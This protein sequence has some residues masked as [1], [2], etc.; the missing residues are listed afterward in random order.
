MSTA[1]LTRRRTA[2]YNLPFAILLLAT[3][4]YT[5]LALAGAVNSDYFALTL[6]A[7]AAFTVHNGDVLSV[8]W[9]S[10]LDQAILYLCCGSKQS[11]K[12]PKFLYLR[13]EA[14][15]SVG[16]YPG[17]SGNEQLTFTLNTS[18]TSPC[19][20]QYALQSAES[21]FFDG[22]WVDVPNEKATPVVT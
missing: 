13:Y 21:T 18:C 14:N 17:L 16:R 12:S 3:F 15:D 19:H 20:W 8:T 4:T 9:F 6:K 7:A 5:R 11:K 22:G 1:V 10:T 2:L